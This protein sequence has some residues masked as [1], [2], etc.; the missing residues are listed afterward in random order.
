MLF[1]ECLWCR[2]SAGACPA[3]HV[4]CPPPAMM[5]DDSAW[6]AECC[7]RHSGAGGG[8]KRARPDPPPAGPQAAAHGLVPRAL[9]H[10]CHAGLLAQG[11]P[12]SSPLHTDEMNQHI[13]C[14]LAQYTCALAAQHLSKRIRLDIVLASSTDIN[15][16]DVRC[17]EAK[18]IHRPPGG[19]R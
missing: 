10:N 3:V 12:Q 9:L 13:R 2:I 6:H 8:L 19:G 4:L 1:A 7:K 14:R 18:G 5:S 17:A 15:T 16:R 11:D